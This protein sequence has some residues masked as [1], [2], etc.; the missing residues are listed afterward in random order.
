VR[1][2]LHLEDLLAEAAKGT[3]PILGYI[4]PCCAC[5]Y[6]ILGIAYLRVVDIVT[7]CAYILFHVVKILRVILYTYI[8]Y[9]GLII[10]RA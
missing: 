5:R 7:C 6:A 2:L 10:L 8:Y 4:L 9:R 3:C 1:L